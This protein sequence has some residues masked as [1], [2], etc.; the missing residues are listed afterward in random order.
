MLLS[1]GAEYD[2]EALGRP[3]TRA[4]RDEMLAELSDG[5][6]PRLLVRCLVEGP[7][8]A[9]RAIDP[10]TRRRIFAKEMAFALAVI[11]YGDRFFF[12]RHPELDQARVTVEFQS[13]DPR[14]QARRGYGRI[15]EYRVTRI[16]GES[17]RLLVGAAAVAAV[18]IGAFV[19]GKLRNRG[20]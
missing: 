12:E 5:D 11:R 9:G 19:V 20:G 7:E 13:T 6:Q 8:L 17:R 18:G 15:T 4:M 16:A 14:F 10:G 1:V 3:E 2:Q